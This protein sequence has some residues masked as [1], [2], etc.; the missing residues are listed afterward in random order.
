MPMEFNVGEFA[1][2]V[3]RLM[4]V[5]GRMPFSLDETLIG[6]VAVADSQQSPWRTTGRSVRASIRI[7]PTALQFAAVAVRNAGTRP[8]VIEEL[9]VQNQSG[10]LH[11]VTL[12]FAPSTGAFAGAPTAVVTGITGE[13]QGSAEDPPLVGGTYPI[14][15]L[16]TLELDSY[17]NAGNPQGGVTRFDVQ[18]QLPAGGIY[19]LAPDITL[20]P[21][22][23]ATGQFALYTVTAGAADA[24]LALSVRVRSYD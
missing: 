1:Q 9:I 8:F 10:I 15:L 2:R 17:S 7:T 13:L 20:W 23:A 19:T 18:L 4:G 16:P 6:T 5:R 24:Q 11:T 21:V 14:Q 3:R 22:V 12:G